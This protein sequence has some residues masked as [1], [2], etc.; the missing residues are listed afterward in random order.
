MEHGGLDIDR[1][2]EHDGL[3]AQAYSGFEVRPEQLKMAR[4]VGAAF[5]D[6]C[7]LAVEAGTGVG[8]SFAYLVPA[9]SQ[10][11]LK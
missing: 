5:D 1:I 11:L 8:K 7:H 10:V 6:R 2:F 3:V 9:I 4:A